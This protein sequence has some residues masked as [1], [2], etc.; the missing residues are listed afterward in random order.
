MGKK[1]SVA[2]EVK[3]GS[4]QTF[5]RIR[6]N[7]RRGHRVRGFRA[8]RRR[9]ETPLR[10]GGGFITLTEVILGGWERPLEPIIAVLAVT[11]ADRLNAG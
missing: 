9:R 11:S 8:R 5:K 10:W 2:Q 6:G 1:Q 4:C 7:V 3:A